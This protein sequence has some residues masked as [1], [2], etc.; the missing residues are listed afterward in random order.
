VSRAVD[1]EADDAGPRALAPSASAITTFEPTDAALAACLDAIRPDAYARTRNHLDGAVTGLSPYL[2]HGFI[3]T[4]GVRRALADRG[5]VL[6]NDHKL[7]FELGWREYFRHVWRHEGEGILASLHEGPRPDAAYAR[8]LP[9]DLREARTGVP[10]IDRAVTGLYATGWL[11]NHARMWLASYT[12]HLRGVHWRTGA[13][14]MLSHLL[15]GDLASNHLS[16]QW[17][18]GTGSHKPYLF[19]AENVERWAGPDW[20]SPGTVIDTSYEVLDAI[21]RGHRAVRE[22]G[23]RASAAGVD[24]PAV[25]ARPPGAQGL[26]VPTAAA[27]AG[28]RLRLVHPWSLARPADQETGEEVVAAWVSDRHDRWPWSARRWAFVGARMQE[29]APT[30]FLGTASQWREALGAAHRV[31]AV[32][33]PHLDGAF[34]G[35]ADLQAPPTLFADPGRPCRSFSQ[36]WN[37]VSRDPRG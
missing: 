22:V 11:H 28:R 9:A 14:W 10:A 15:D 7:V 3:S 37:R 34:A 12:V 4:A 35:I 23:R 5:H 31:W 18:A 27:F 33:D 8:E 36:W 29:L 21:A 13:D 30:G 24:E 16:W 26:P 1:T 25:F 19:N 2:A 20:H 17:V 6:R 32:D